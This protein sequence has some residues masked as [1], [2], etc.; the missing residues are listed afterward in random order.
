[1]PPRE[2]S[3]QPTVFL[4]L[5][6]T[7]DAISQDR[8]GMQVSQLVQ[9]QSAFTVEAAS[10]RDF[11]DALKCAVRSSVESMNELHDKLTPCVDF[12]RR[13]GVGPVQ[14]ILSIKACAIQHAL[15]SQA[16]GDELALTNAHLLME[17][18]VKWAI[19]EYYR[20]E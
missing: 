12:L 8:R 7:G 5:G 15:E 17:Q 19:I 14:M 2:F 9:K 16:S 3:H 1:M 11:G 6:A 10:A 20:S 4:W 18:I 13:S